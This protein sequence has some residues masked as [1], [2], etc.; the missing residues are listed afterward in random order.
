M[1]FCWAVSVQLRSKKTVLSRI[2]H[3]GQISK[4]KKGV[5]P[6]KFPLKNWIKSCADKKNRADELTDWRTGQKHYTLR[7]S[8]RGVLKQTSC[9]SIFLIKCKLVWM[10]CYV[11]RKL[12]FT[13]IKQNAAFTRLD[14]NLLLTVRLF[15][16][17][18]SYT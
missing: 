6:I 8:L 2:F 10:V 12:K 13:F 4:F 3:F 17:F 14:L 5:I 16:C 1:K 18:Y 11:W 15:L 7:H 9:S